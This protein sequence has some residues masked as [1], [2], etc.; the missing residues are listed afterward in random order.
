MGP[1]LI[2]LNGV[3]QNPIESSFD[4]KKCKELILNSSIMYALELLGINNLRRMFKK[5]TS[6]IEVRNIN[7]EPSC[8]V[9][10]HGAFLVY[11]PHY[12]SKADFAFYPMTFLYLE[13]NILYYLCQKNGFTTYYDKS[14]SVIHKEDASAKL[15]NRSDRKRMMFTYKNQLK[16]AKL[17]LRLIKEDYSID[18]INEMCRV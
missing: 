16:S 15:L 7:M 1:D 2:T 8:G 6:P 14:I 11:S 4:A 12:I 5:N 9:A 13:E 3:H 18:E 10:L 17:F